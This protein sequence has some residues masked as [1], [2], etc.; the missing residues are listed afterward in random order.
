MARGGRVAAR[1]ARATVGAILTVG[2]AYPYSL[3]CQMQT[4]ANADSEDGPV[5]V[6]QFYYTHT[7]RYLIER[8]R[9]EIGQ[10][11]KDVPQGLRQRELVPS[12]AALGETSGDPA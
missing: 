8:W 10:R 7:F 12:L 4:S 9:Q 11:L 2:I 1:G 6:T 5:F 3:E